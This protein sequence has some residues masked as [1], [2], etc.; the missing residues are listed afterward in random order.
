MIDSSD[1]LDSVC[2][3]NVY[4][5]AVVSPSGTR[6]KL[7]SRKLSVVVHVNSNLTVAAPIAE[8]AV[9]TL[10]ASVHFNL[11][12]QYTHLPGCAF[13]MIQYQKSHHR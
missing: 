2:K 12:S 5:L 9:L 4:L 3:I 11:T 6:K 1:V 10:I 7:H 13:K 8:I